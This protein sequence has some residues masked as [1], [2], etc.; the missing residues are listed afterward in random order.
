M[1]GHM[2]K[3]YNEKANFYKALDDHVKK[4]FWAILAVIRQAEN[5]KAAYRKPIGFI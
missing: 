4:L 5:Y 1:V 3:Q 2:A